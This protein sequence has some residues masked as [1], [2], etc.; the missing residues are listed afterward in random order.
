MYRQLVLAVALAPLMVFS[1][2][3]SP[4]VLLG[5]TVGLVA[6]QN[7]AACGVSRE[8]CEDR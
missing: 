7:S 4:R 3:S 1:A 5:D 8:V 6:R 2:T